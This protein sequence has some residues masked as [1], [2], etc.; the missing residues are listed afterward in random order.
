MTFELTVKGDICNSKGGE[1]RY[2]LEKTKGYIQH[3]QKGRDGIPKNVVEGVK[4]RRQF[5]K[6]EWRGMKQC[7][8][9]I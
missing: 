7:F 4:K 5:E 8:V 6:V 2:K 3:K 1:K 9:L